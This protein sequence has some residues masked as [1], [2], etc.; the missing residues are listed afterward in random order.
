MLPYG[1]I[2]KIYCIFFMLFMCKFLL[3]YQSI[4]KSLQRYTRNSFTVAI[5]SKLV[6]CMGWQD[7]LELEFCLSKFLVISAL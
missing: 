2:I 3:V 5:L 6:F 4:Q 7:H 1:V